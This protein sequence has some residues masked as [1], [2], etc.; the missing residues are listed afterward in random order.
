MTRPASLTP[1]KPHFPPLSHPLISQASPIQPKPL[2]TSLPMTTAIHEAIPQHF[3]IQPQTIRPRPPISLP[4]EGGSHRRSSAVYVQ[5]M[6]MPRLPTFQVLV[7][8]RNIPP[9][10][11]PSNPSGPAPLIATSQPVR[12]PVTCNDISKMTCTVHVYI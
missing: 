6:G 10:L 1:P 12:L 3:K 5:P 7:G 4:M 11:R 9:K 8:N 2:V